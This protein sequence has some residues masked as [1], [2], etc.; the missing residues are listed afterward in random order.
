MKLRKALG[1][2]TISGLDAGVKIAYGAA[3]VC[4][5]GLPITG[6]YLGAT[7]LGAQLVSLFGA[8]L[9]GTMGGSFISVAGAVAGGFAGLLGG[10]MAAIPAVPAAFYTF[11]GASTLTGTILGG[12]VGATGKAVGAVSSARPKIGKSKKKTAE[13]PAKGNEKSPV[14]DKAVKETFKDAKKAGPVAKQKKKPTPKKS[15]ITAKR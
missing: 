12:T 7:L 2:G 13:G 10:I 15:E 4:A 3:A 11:L 14:G 1:N 5:L 9:A 8:G 6:A